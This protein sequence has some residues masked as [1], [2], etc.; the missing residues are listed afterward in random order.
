MNLISKPVD[1]SPLEKA[2]WKICNVPIIEPL[3]HSYTDDSFSKLHIWNMTAY[4]RILW[5]DSD[6]MPTQDVGPLLEKADSLISPRSSKM[7]P[8]I[9]PSLSMGG[10]TTMMNMG[11]FIIKP[12]FEEY[13]WLMNLHKNPMVSYLIFLKNLPKYNP[14]ITKF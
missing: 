2:G 3:K 5:I 12:D 9:V 10:G 14:R 13:L 11:L 7:G 4:S 1:T 8:R 6:I